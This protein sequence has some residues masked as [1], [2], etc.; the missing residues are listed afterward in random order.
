MVSIAKGLKF[1]IAPKNHLLVLS[2]GWNDHQMLKAGYVGDP[3]V[4]DFM[5]NISQQDLKFGFPLGGSVQNFILTMKPKELNILANQM[6]GSKKAFDQAGLDHAERQNFISVGP[7]G[8]WSSQLKDPL[9]IAYIKSKKVLHPQD[10]PQSLLDIVK[11]GGN[12]LLKM[13]LID[14]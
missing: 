3:E 4:Y 13:E 6:F 7:I 14:E 12:E 10:Y 5:L 9:E 1:V 8:F 11:R 2:R